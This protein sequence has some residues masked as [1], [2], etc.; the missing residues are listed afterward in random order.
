MI[1]VEI[2]VVAL[3]SYRVWRLFGA[4]DITAPIRD[5]LDGWAHLLVSCPWCLGT[6]VT[7]IIG[8]LTELAGLTT[9]SPWLLIP[10]AATVVGLIGKID[11]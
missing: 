1:L 4:D 9:A 7:I 5:R 11:H 10:A 6:W 8:F 2:V 3:V